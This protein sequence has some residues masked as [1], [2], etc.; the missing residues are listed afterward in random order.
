MSNESYLVFASNAF[1]IL[2]LRAMY[3]LLANAKERIHYLSHALGGILIFVGV[4]MSLSHWYHMNTYVSLAII[5]AM[6]VMA[7]LLSLRLT[8][9]RGMQV[10]VSTLGYVMTDAPP[11]TRSDDR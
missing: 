5:V 9:R 2:G 6:L 11:T 1:A 7:V 8:R 10:A 4:K 3:F